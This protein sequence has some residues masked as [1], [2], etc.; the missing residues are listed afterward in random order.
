MSWCHD[1]PGQI[2]IARRH[3]WQEWRAA[4]ETEVNDVTGLSGTTGVLPTPARTHRELE[5]IALLWLRVAQVLMQTGSR[6][7][8]VHEWGAMLKSGLGVD[9]LGLRVGYASISVTLGSGGRPSLT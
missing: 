2:N 1:D 4:S 9:L 5:Q 8:V 7:A 6:A 3:R